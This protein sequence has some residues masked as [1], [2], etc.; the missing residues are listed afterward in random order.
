MS[1]FIAILDDNPADR[2][3]SE[4]L[5]SRERDVRNKNNEVIY[6]DT[7]GSRDAILPVCSKYDLI[8]VDI[9]E[10]PQDGFMAAVELSRSGADGQFVLA[11]SK[12]DYRAKY[13]AHD[14]FVFID[15]PL[16]QQ[17][18]SSLVDLAYSHKAHQIK[19][20]EL[21]DKDTTIHVLP[22]EILYMRQKSYYTI[23]ALSGDRSFHASDS[24]DQLLPSL[25][26]L[27]FLSTDETTVLNMRHV[28]SRDKNSFK[29]SDGAVIRFS[30]FNKRRILRTFESYAKK[31]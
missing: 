15:K 10:S 2:K 4:R 1:L 11:S 6:F 19:K 20:I 18:I 29:M 21:R 24:L 5:L 7:Y 27:T 26:P 13:G 17:H 31:L 30:I 8:L 16:Y 28:V 25:D 23:V 9:T 3:Q 14:D 22:D 12:I